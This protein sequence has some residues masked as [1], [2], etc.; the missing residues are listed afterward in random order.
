M[1]G[2]SMQAS[3][4]RVLSGMRVTGKLHLGHYHG[5]L[6]NW[7]RLQSQYN[8]FFCAVDWHA[9][10]THYTDPRILNENIWD[11]I[12]DWLAVGIDPKQ[13][14]VFIQ[15]DVPETAELHLLLSMITPVSWLE[16]IPSYKDQQANLHEKD[17]S[18]YGFLGYPMLQSADILL[19]KASLVP[20]GEDQ[21]SHIEFTREVARRFNFLYGRSGNT[22][23]PEPKALLAPHSKLTG[24]DG[25][26]M[27]KSYH[28]TI[29]L[30]ESPADIAHKI[31][32]MPTDPA[33][34]KRTDPGEPEKCPVWPLHQVYSTPDVKSWVQKGCRS[35]GIGCLDC[36]Q[37]VIDSIQKEVSAIRER[38]QEYEENPS[39]VKHIVAQGAEK[40][41][42]IARGTLKEVKETMGLLYD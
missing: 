38:A 9:L 18:T 3:Q 31:R 36:K 27:S 10:T 35:A 42:D 33:R 13:A 37:P 11:M 23:L 20:V 16:R 26:K 2:E 28:N 6:K 1:T 39:L 14:T 30:R 29:S 17:L 12:I 21:V 4:S 22:I 7:A 15:S 32:T 19:Y 40:A 8:C 24:L 25:R 5:V 41:R 34:I